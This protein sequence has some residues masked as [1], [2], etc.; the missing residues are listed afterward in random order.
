MFFL[1]SI[2]K[3]SFS[4]TCRQQLAAML[5]SNLRHKFER[6]DWLISELWAPWAAL[7]F[8]VSWET[9]TTNRGNMI[10]LVWAPDYKA[11]SYAMEDIRYSNNE[12][13]WR[14]FYCK[15]LCEA[16]KGP[17]F[18]GSSVQQDAFKVILCRRRRGERFLLYRSIDLKREMQWIV[19]LPTCLRR[20]SRVSRLTTKHLLRCCTEMVVISHQDTI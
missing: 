18:R 16:C 10:V 8:F 5:D 9:G 3:M 1:K 12:R 11:P 2:S 15:E 4:K 14:V 7:V 6:S 13:K 20:R 17:T 19:R